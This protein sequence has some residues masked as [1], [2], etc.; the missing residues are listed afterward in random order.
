MKKILFHLLIQKVFSALVCE[1]FSIKYITSGARCT[2]LGFYKCKFVYDLVVPIRVC[3]T[4]YNTFR[5][6]SL[7][8]LVLGFF[9]TFFQILRTSLCLFFAHLHTYTQAI[10]KFLLVWLHNLPHKTKITVFENHYGQPS[11]RPLILAFFVKL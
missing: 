11:I 6:S 5:T 9:C 2:L 3:T 4:Q 8:E 7:M 1:T 10:K